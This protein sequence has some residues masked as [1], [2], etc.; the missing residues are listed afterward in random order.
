MA[1]Q[2]LPQYPA[3]GEWFALI[4]CEVEISRTINLK[5]TFRVIT[6]SNL[7][8]SRPIKKNSFWVSNFLFGTS[9][10]VY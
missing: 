1:P 5:N 10:L 6:D 4:T 8:Q 2:C 3:R 9:D 7:T